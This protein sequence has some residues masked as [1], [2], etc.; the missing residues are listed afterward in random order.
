[1][2]TKKNLDW[3]KLY[4]LGKGLWKGEDAQ[5]HVNRLRKDRKPAG[6]KVRTFK[7]GVK[8]KSVKMDRIYGY[9]RQPYRS[10]PDRQPEAREA[11]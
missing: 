11:C 8:K 7:L 1:M 2:K 3:N 9:R 6:T 10:L 5:E 4:G